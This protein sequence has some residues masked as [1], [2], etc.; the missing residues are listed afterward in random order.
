[1]RVIIM[2]LLALPLVRSDPI[3]TLFRTYTPSDTRL[4]CM[5][6]ACSSLDTI[7]CFATPSTLH[8]NKYY[9]RC[10]LREIRTYIINMRMQDD[11]ETLHINMTPRKNQNIILDIIRAAWWCVFLYHYPHLTLG[12]MTGQW[13]AKDSR[14]RHIEISFYV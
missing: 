6:P 4:K 10:R 13:M 14:P 7:R 2:I 11:Y 1:M 9:W 5:S 8:D 12:L 3:P